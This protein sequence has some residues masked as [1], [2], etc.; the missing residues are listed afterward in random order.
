ME[1]REGLYYSVS[2]SAQTIYNDID[3]TMLAKL[4]DL[5]A[6]GIYAAAYRIIDVSVVPATSMRAAAYPGYF[7][8]GQNG[9]SSSLAYTRRLLPKPILLSIVILAALLIGAPIVISFLGNKYAASVEV[10]RW[11]APLPLLKTMHVF[12]A[13]ALTGAGY[14]RLRTVIQVAVAGFNVLFNLWIIPAYSWRG[15]AWSSIVSDALLACMCAGALAII[16]SMQKKSK[17]LMTIGVG[18]I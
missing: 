12:L 10:L 17:P 2:Q 13:D 4:G 16:S 9:V 7:R 18:D 5:S 14:Q 6:A 15:A 8:A 1:L 3:K 11:L